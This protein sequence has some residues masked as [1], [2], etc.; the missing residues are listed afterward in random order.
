MKSQPSLMIRE[1]MKKLTLRISVKPKL[2]SMITVFC[3]IKIAMQ[4]SN[5]KL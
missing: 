2:D 1:K 4:M 5:S 3:E